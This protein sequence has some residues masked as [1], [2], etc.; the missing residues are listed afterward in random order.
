M[1]LRCGCTQC[2][3]RVYPEEAKREDYRV[4]FNAMYVNP[5]HLM[6]LPKT[7][8]IIAA[9]SLLIAV[10]GAQE[11]KVVLRR[12]MDELYETTFGKINSE[13]EMLD[14][15]QSRMLALERIAPHKIII[16][17]GKVNEDELREFRNR[18]GTW[19]AGRA[20]SF[21]SYSV[22]TILYFSDINEAVMAK[23]ELDNSERR[24]FFPYRR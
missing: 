16:A 20:A 14:C 9:S 8:H 22:G 10:F 3:S 2:Y 11:G 12:R 13:Q 7:D 18:S 21:Y 15:C 24:R 23:F 4:V 6:S 5:T 17:G 1:S 19:R